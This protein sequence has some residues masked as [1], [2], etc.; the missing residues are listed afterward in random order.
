MCS[1]FRLRWRGM[2]ISC[3]NLCRSSVLPWRL[4]YSLCCRSCS[5]CLQGATECLLPLVRLVDMHLFL[6]GISSFSY[7]SSQFGQ[8]LVLPCGIN[9]QN[10]NTIA[11]DMSDPET[12]LCESVKSIKPLIP[13]IDVLSCQ[14]CLFQVRLR[15]HVLQA[16]KHTQIISEFIL[17]CK[18]PV[19]VLRD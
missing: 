13:P 17:M 19:N 9:E 12:M 3:Q 2:L 8:W 15:G 7:I 10:E 18:I 6:G 5:F 11:E 16:Y 4:W 1:A 14:I